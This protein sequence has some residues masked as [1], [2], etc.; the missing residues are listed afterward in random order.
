M[1]ATRS[2]LLVEDDP[3][4]CMI[5][6]RILEPWDLE[7]VTTSSAYDAI[8][9]IRKR[10]FDFYSIDLQ[11]L[12][13]SADGL[14][15]VLESQGEATAS[16]CVVVTSFDILAPAFTR[17]PIVAKTRLS[18]LGPHLTRI[19]GTPAAPCAGAIA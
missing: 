19:L 9:L 14:L 10:S 8:E 12:D 17:F 15:S 1:N 3:N 2:A 6:T 11:L 7:I 13:E 5:Y 18:T 16:R 4:F